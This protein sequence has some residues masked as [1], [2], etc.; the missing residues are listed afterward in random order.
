MINLLA[1]AGIM[2]SIDLRSLVL[3]RKSEPGALPCQTS[4]SNV[5]GVTSS[6][7]RQGE[8]RIEAAVKVKLL[9]PG[10]AAAESLAIARSDGGHAGHI[11]GLP[12][13]RAMHLGSGRLKQ[14]QDSRCD[15]PGVSLSPGSLANRSSSQ[16]QAP[17]PCSVFSTAQRAPETLTR[18]AAGGQLVAKAPPPFSRVRKRWVLVPSHEALE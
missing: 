14:R 5:L 12:A 9:L 3:A 13:N 10:P 17:A 8:Q 18:L 4:A 1:L 6:S 16:A 11:I 7:S 15:W 2:G